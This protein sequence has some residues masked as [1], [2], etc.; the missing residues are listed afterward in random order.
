M[1]RFDYEYEDED[2]DFGEDNF[3]PEEDVNVWTKQE[4][5]E[6]LERREALDLMQLEMVQTDLNQKLLSKT[7]KMLE[8][9]FFWRFRSNKTKL[10]MIAE[11]YESL[12]ILSAISNG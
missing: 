12:K 7:I 1:K 11:T 2:D 6:H 4:E 8:N 5:M 3:F 9:S 10:K